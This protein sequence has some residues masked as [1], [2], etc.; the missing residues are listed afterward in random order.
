[1]R[2]FLL[3]AMLILTSAIHSRVGTADKEC[4]NNSPFKN[5]NKYN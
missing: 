4:A 1:M 5:L 3:L 2:S